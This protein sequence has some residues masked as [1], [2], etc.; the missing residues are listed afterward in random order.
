MAPPLLTLRN[1]HLKIGSQTLF[2]ELDVAIGR[3][4]R[5]CLVGRN[6]AGKSTLLKA[7]AGLIDLD[8]GERFLQSRTTV[9]YLPQDPD[10]PAGTTALEVTLLGLAADRDPETGRH[11]AISALSRFGIDP[12]LTSDAVSGGEARRIALARAL[13]GEPEILLLDEPTNHLDIQAIERLEGDLGS[14]RG[15]VVMISHDR[16]FLSSLSKRTWWLDRGQ[17][18]VLDQGFDAFERWSQDLLAEEETELHRLSKAIEAE[19][20]WLHFGVTARRKRNQGRLRRLRAMRQDRAERLRPEGQ[21]KLEGQSAGASGRLVIEATSIAKSFGECSIIEDF[22]TRVMR[23]DRIGIIGPNG[24]GKTTLIRMLTGELAPDQGQVRLGTKLDIARID[25]RR[26]SL[27]PAK[28]PWQTLCPD[29]GDQVEVQGRFRHV[30]GYLRDFLFRPEQ[31][32][33]PIRA[34]SGGERN[35]LLL[36]KQ[37][38]HPANLLVMDEPTNDLDMETLDLLQE[39]L[40][41]FDGTLLLVSHDRDFLDRLVT[42]T[43]ALEGDG[44]AMEYAGGYS[45]YLRQRSPPTADGRLGNAVPART[46][47]TK[48]DHRQ[49]GRQARQAERDRARLEK[50]IERLQNEKAKLETALADPD[51]YTKD[52]GA[53]AANTEALERL[54]RALDEAEE[55]WLALE[56][57]A[58][59]SA[60]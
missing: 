36:A 56:L 49:A 39:M 18:C 17:V 9:A 25:Q 7:I 2:A 30:V 5:V 33:T 31:L 16:R 22:S 29:G 23:G 13:V 38:A 35:R 3:D 34:L 15:A 10:L 37:L 28:S 4:D 45:D 57:E 51:L 24:A 59:A 44:K 55:R 6:G 1:A 26:D 41:D 32:R 14:F 8:S 43:I 48:E 53:F 21:V 20:E 50:Q 12:N 47:R 42:S 11:L 52:P 46:V 60:S 19:T 40:T 27:D 54:Q 58:E